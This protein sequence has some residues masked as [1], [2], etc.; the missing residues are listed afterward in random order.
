MATSDKSDN[1]LLQLILDKIDGLKDLLQKRK[2]P[3]LTIQETSEYLGVSKN[4]LYGYTSKGILPFYKLRNRKLYFRISDLNR[5]VLS[6]ENR[7]ED[8]IE[9]GFENKPRRT[10]ISDFDK[11]MLGPKKRKEKLSKT[12]KENEKRKNQ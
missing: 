2:K 4:T 6:P 10:P 3:F 11:F 8:F 5:F 7:V 12:G 9:K 1:Y